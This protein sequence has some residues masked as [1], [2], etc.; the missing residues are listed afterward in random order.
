M[1][2]DDAFRFDQGLELAEAFYRAAQE[3]KAAVKTLSRKY[4]IAPVTVSTGIAVGSALFGPTENKAAQATARSLS[5]GFSLDKLSVINRAVK[6][7][8]NPTKRADFRTELTQSAPA[9]TCV[10]LKQKANSLLRERNHVT[11]KDSWK[12]RGLRLSL[13]S[14]AMGV[15]HATLSLPAADMAEL[16][17]LI[18]PTARHAINKNPNLSQEQAM[19]DALLAHLGKDQIENPLNQPKRTCILLSADDL[20]PG[21]DG[22][23]IDTNGHEH[24]YAEFAHMKLEEDFF[25]VLYFKNEIIHAGR[26][27]FA[28]PIQDLL[29]SVDQIMCAHPDC[30]RPANHCQSHHITAYKNGGETNLP[31]LLKACAPHNAANDDDPNRP[32]NGR[33]ERHPE[34]KQAGYRP[35]NGTKLEFNKHPS[36]NKSGRVW[37]NQKYQES[38]IVATNR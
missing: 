15:C 22:Y 10:E 9:L 29:L 5:K 20:K 1:N 17:N 8:N 13:Q 32:L 21:R 31:N 4:G 30:E 28:T 16:N 14:D 18:Y 23:L 6:L 11:R 19:V 38:D 36:V 26:S 35:P 27:R 34:T 7:L 33:L 37:A 24:T 3:T 2:L 25:H 12:R